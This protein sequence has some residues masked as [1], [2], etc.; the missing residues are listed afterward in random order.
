MVCLIA[1]CRSFI[2][3]LNI[4]GPGID[5]RGIPLKIVCHERTRFRVSRVVNDPISNL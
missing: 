5:R 4:G 1:Q 2:K 3:I